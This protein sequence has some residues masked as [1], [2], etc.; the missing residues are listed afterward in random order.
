MATRNIIPS[1]KTPNDVYSILIA[2]VLVSLLF[3]GS[4]LGIWGIMIVGLILAFTTQY[5]TESTIPAFHAGILKNSFTGKMRVLF[6]GVNFKLPWEE[7]QEKTIDLRIELTE[8]SKPETY[9]SLDAEMTVTCVS[10]FRPD[11]TEC[12]GE[13]VGEKILLFSSFE[14]K[15]IQEKGKALFSMLLSDYYASKQGKDLLKKEEIN[16][17]VFGTETN[18]NIKILN[19]E[20]RHGVEVTVRLTD[21]DFSKAAQKFRDM[22]SGAD[23][24]DKAINKLVSGGMERSK[25][26]KMVKLMNLDGYTEKDI[27][28]NVNAPDLKNLRDVTMLGSANDEKKGKK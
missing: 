23:S 26:E 17:T 13:D 8:P 19:F 14:P 20:K 2:T 21:S 27:N 11:L 5:Y 4:L 15:A 3:F 1:T 10:T 22:I 12:F 16:N 25:A 6:P 9:D 24:I 7:A 18:P 28:L